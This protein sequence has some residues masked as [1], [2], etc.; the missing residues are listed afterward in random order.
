MKRTYCY[1]LTYVDG[2]ELYVWAHHHEVL[3]GGEVAFYNKVEFESQPPLFKFWRTVARGQWK[4]FET[5]DLP[6]KNATVIGERP[7]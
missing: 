6:P 1:H 7:R 2:K 5:I 3:P 4:E